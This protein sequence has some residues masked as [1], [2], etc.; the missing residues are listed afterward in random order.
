MSTQQQEP[1]IK[2]R[3]VE[4]IEPAPLPPHEKQS[5]RTE[6]DEDVDDTDEA[7]EEEIDAKLNPQDDLHR[8]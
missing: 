4:H 2:K 1:N 7:N 8:D 3:A 5:L 6:P